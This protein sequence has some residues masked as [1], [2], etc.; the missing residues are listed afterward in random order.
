MTIYKNPCSVFFDLLLKLFMPMILFFTFFICSALAEPSRLVEKTLAVVEDQMVSMSDLNMA[1]KRIKNG[2]MDQSPL[3]P[4]FPKLKQTKSKKVIK[5]LVAQLVSDLA[6]KQVPGLTVTDEEL[7]AEIETQRKLKK[8][9]RESFSRFLIKNNFTSVSYKEFLRKALKRRKIIQFHVL[10]K[11]KLTDEDLNSHSLSTGSS[12]LF[13]SFKYDL[14]Y[15][16]FPL[17]QEGKQL[18][19]KTLR[20]LSSTQSLKDLSLQVEG[21]QFIRSRELSGTKAQRKVRKALSHLSVGQHTNVVRLSSGFH[22][23][24]ILGK[25]PEIPLENKSKR[26]LI[27]AKLFQQTYIQSLA[28]WLE[29]NRSSSFVKIHI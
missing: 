2:F 19:N 6:A 22:I 9:D 3:L 23:F 25:T 18:A 16:V 29:K 14:E 20:S 15:L 11:I 1:K 13:T 8:M 5:F 21:V 7:M 27:H 28:A 12:P 10:E 24:K 26:D 4:A 17:T